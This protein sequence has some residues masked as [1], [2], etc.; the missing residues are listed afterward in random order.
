MDEEYTV[1]PPSAM[2]F[3]VHVVAY[4]QTDVSA[5]QIIHNKVIAIASGAST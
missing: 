2:L 5:P 3:I 4:P 1:M